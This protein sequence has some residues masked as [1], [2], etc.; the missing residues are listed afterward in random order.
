MTSEQF[1]NWLEFATRMARNGWPHLTEHRRTILEQD[2]REFIEVMRP[3]MAEIN[4]WDQG[5]VVHVCDYVREFFD[6]HDHY[7]QYGERHGRYSDQLQCCIRAGLDVAAEPSAGVIGFSVGDVRR[8]FDGVLPLWVASVF[9]S[10]TE[11]T[12]DGD[13]I[14]L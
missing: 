11:A 6:M 5:P 8:M 13:G 7:D 1:E 14:W 9:P 12:P 2:V 4:D 3:E 10:L